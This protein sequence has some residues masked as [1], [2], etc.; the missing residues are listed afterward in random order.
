LSSAREQ[1]IQALYRAALDRPQAERASFVAAL[2][3]G[4]EQV[5]QAVEQLLARQD[6]TD[7]GA[8]EISP[9]QAPAPALRAG[10]EIGQYSIESVLGQGGMGIVYRATDRKLNRP[11]AIKFLSSALADAAARHRFQQEAATTSALN[12]P[13]IVTV[14]DV[15]EHDGEPYIVSELV[16]GGTLD[17]WSAAARRSWRQSV[18]L[19]TGVADG[20]AAAHSAGILHRDVKPGNILIGG[21]G[22][23]KIA[24]FG[25]AKL[26]NA[27]GDSAHLRARTT[28]A[29]VVVGTVAYMSP[30]QAT[31]QALDAR[32]DIF[33]FGVVLYELVT[34]KRPFVGANDLEVLKAIAHGTPAPLPEETPELVRL[35]LDKALEKEPGDRYQTMQDLVADLKRVTR[36]SGSSQVRVAARRAPALSRLMA[37]GLG[38]ALAAALVPATLYFSRPAPPLP[39]LQL[40]FAAPGAVANGLAVS[41][42]GRQIA[43]AAIVDGVRRIWLRPI[44]ARE[45]RVIEGTENAAS[46]FWS[47]DSRQIAFIADGNLKRV[48]VAS[49]ASQS[50][51][52]GAGSVPLPGSWSPDDT[53]LFSAG[54]FV[55]R[56]PATGGAPTRLAEAQALG[57]GGAQGLPLALPDGEHY[58]YLT[59]Q[60]TSQ[61]DA[62]M[63]GS[64]ATPDGSALFNVPR[65]S[66]PERVPGL[67]Y[68]NGLLL[69]IREDTLVAQPFDAERLAVRGDA[70]PIA[71]NVAEFSVSPMVLVYR[72][73]SST[74]AQGL[75]RRL[76]WRDRNGQRVGEV[77]VSAPY[78][79]PALSPDGRRVAVSM[80]AANEPFLEDIYSIDVERGSATRVT[81]H[82]A[83]DSFAAW[84]A[85]GTRLVFNSGRDGVFALPSALYERA[86]SGAGTERL[87]FSA[88]DPEHVLLP[89]DWS[90]AYLLFGRAAAAEFTR[91]VDI[92]AL[93]I[94]NQA[95]AF[96]VIESAFRKGPARLSP[97]GRWMAYVS[98]ESSGDQIFVQPFP[99][100]GQGK[101]QVTATGGH[102]PRWRADGR[103]LFYLSPAGEVMAVETAAGE[104]F[105]PGPP[106]TLFA[107]GMTIIGGEV[108]PNSYYAV[109]A[110][111]E[112]FLINE[113]GASSD[114]TSSS[115]AAA[116]EPQIHVIVNWN[117]RSLAE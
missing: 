64:F 16:D 12:H 49:G 59:T 110:D 60:L 4:D 25:L 22:Y 71:D 61:T 91:H 65:P 99:D 103:E 13:H 96:P 68:S 106:R 31:G 105:E 67:A 77:A 72:E 108:I 76:I 44:D 36:K 98:N 83:R 89:W 37:A 70:V 111:G 73:I 58:L 102:D 79:Q 15:G 30:E 75:P 114:E 9:P 23:A 1:Q 41:P 95:R 63:L 34:G 42:D 43:Y 35:T 84:S 32:S 88:G 117:A 45:A 90:G 86:A 66:D 7:V 8:S 47:P 115:S 57:G 93:D 100:V 85:D 52:S 104:T 40:A 48:D 97:D 18:E 6:A 3:A 92:W 107:T 46:L 20:L 38:V 87:L 78:F 55:S 69:F 54:I 101:W 94:S 112:R 28:R 5:R 39:H 26:V 74:D 116:T 17:D 62:I 11:V 27:T 109:T 80:N 19:M 2:S 82:D 53:I 21:K 81:F 14:Y 50:I 51:A 33:S 113:P 29:G 10:T 56:V 24:D